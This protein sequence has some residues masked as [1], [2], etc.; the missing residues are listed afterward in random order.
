MIIYKQKFTVYVYD[1][2]V[3]RRTDY[4]HKRY[5]LIR[6]IVHQCDKGPAMWLTDMMATVWEC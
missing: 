4:G 2:L 3:P 1:N 6:A 5:N